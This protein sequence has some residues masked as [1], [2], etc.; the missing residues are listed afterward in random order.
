MKIIA[1]FIFLV[2][3]APSASFA[4]QPGSE[5]VLVATAGQDAKDAPAPSTVVIKGKG[6]KVTGVEKKPDQDKDKDEKKKG[7]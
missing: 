3:L 7:E 2:L 4:D 1:L 5:P 6:G